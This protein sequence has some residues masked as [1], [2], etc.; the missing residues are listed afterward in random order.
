MTLIFSFIGDRLDPAVVPWLLSPLLTS[1]VDLLSLLSTLSKAHLGYL[2]LVRAF[3]RWS[4][5]CYSNSGLLHTVVALWERVWMTL[6][7]LR[8]DGDYPT[9]STDLYVAPWGVEQCLEL[10]VISTPCR[11]WLL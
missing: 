2:H 4:F 8:G 7:W 10:S 5:S 6:N 9:A 1:L 3:L 11:D